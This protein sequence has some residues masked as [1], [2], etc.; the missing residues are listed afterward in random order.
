MFLK[1][2]CLN[3]MFSS[4]GFYDN[5][6][7]LK[8]IGSFDGI[9]VSQVTQQEALTRLLVEK[10]IFSKEEFLEMMK[11]VNREMKRKRELM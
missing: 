3:N 9:L 10:G 4:G 1:N 11:A 5:P 7:A 8:Q 6:F 2:T